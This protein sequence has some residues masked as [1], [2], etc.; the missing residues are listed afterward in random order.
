MVHPT[1][2]Q[3]IFA[4]LKSEGKELSP[5]QLAWFAALKAVAERTEVLLPLTSRVSAVMLDP[6]LKVF[7][8]RPS[9]WR[10]GTIE[11]VLKGEE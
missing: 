11:R 4:E 1:R 6:L 3:V 5:A 10:D 8:W 9:D 2:R 7:V